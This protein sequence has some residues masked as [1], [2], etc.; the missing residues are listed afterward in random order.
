MIQ[1]HEL[2]Y[3][4]ELYKGHKIIYVLFN[5]KEFIFKSLSRQDYQDI[6]LVSDNEQD[7]EDAVC[8]CALIYPEDFIF[9]KSPLAGL[10][11][12]C[13]KRIIEESDFLDIKRVLNKY[14]LAKEKVMQFDEQCMAVVKS[15]FPEYT[16]DEIMNWTWEKLIQMTARSEKILQIKGVNIQLV[17]QLEDIE[18]DKNDDT[19]GNFDKT[20]FVKKLRENGV[21][22]MKYFKDEIFIDKPYIEYPIIG[23][24]RWKD[25][26]VL[27][28]IRKQMEKRARR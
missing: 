22:P 24:N 17:N 9:P 12:V 23:G 28:A 16:Y 1:L 3:Y 20:E 8:Q 2:L 10:S 18:N 13:A 7:L 27:N 14:N 11:E 5:N 21:D 6:V 19:E 4:K 26:G 15:S 25:E